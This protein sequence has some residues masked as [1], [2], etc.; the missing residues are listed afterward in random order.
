VERYGKVLAAIE[1]GVDLEAPDSPLNLSPDEVQA[2]LHMLDGPVYEY[3]AKLRSY[4]LL[5]LDAFLA[6][7]G[8]VYQHSVT[9]IEHVLPQ[10]VKTGSEWDQLWI[11]EDREHWTNRLG[12]L[13]LLSRAKNSEA[14]NFDFAE[15]KEKY[16]RSKSGVSPYASTTQVLG[17]EQWTVAEVRGRQEELLGIFR[18]GW[19]LG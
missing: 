11:L 15:K 2:T 16:F 6:G 8:A 18:R 3:S 7:V 12:N 19:Q 4:I 10:T 17:Y 14:Q 5:R 9:T 13:V 1:D